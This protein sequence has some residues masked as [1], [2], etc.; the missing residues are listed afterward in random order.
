MN[1]NQIMF[2]RCN[3]TNKSW[4]YWVDNLENWPDINIPQ[5]AVANNQTVAATL[6][7]AIQTELPTLTS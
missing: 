6:A 5:R 3:E 7:S 2:V 1:S 4:T